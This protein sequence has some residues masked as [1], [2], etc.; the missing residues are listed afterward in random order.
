MNKVIRRQ[1][2]ISG[3]LRPREPGSKDKGQR[4]SDPD[5]RDAEP[6]SDSPPL[7]RHESRPPVRH[8]GINE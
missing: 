7:E 5:S 6:R 3:S 8:D 4:P 2:V 1:L